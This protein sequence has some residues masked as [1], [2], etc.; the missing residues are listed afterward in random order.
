MIRHTE[1]RVV[2]YLHVARHFGRAHLSC[3][4]Y[5]AI[6]V[7][8]ISYYLYILQPS[9]LFSWPSALTALDTDTDTDTEQQ[10]H[11]GAALLSWTARTISIVYT[12]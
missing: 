9:L 4:S 7:Q 11:R 2:S 1:Y 10:P 3:I 6:L 12:R 8:T 5:D